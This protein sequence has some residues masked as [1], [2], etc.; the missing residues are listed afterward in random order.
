MGLFRYLAFFL[1]F[2]FLFKFVKRLLFGRTRRPTP[3]D[4]EDENKT[5]EKK[6]HK[7]FSKDEGEYVDYEDLDN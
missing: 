4:F 1:L 5:E 7:I 6:K 3:F 2:Y